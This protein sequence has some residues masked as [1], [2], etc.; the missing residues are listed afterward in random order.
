[1]LYPDVPLYPDVN[2]YPELY[3]YIDVLQVPR[4]HKTNEF[5]NLAFQKFIWQ[6]FLYI[7][8][9]FHRETMAEGAKPTNINISPKIF[10][11]F[12]F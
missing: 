10:N 8:A 11:F 9:I 7:E 5:S 12:L 6:V 2:S 3:M 4:K 1:M